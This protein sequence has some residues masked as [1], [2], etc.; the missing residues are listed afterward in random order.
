[1]TP[2]PLRRNLE[3]GFDVS[4]GWLNSEPK[5]LRQTVGRSSREARS[6]QAGFHLFMPP[7]P[8][9]TSD[10]ATHPKIML[11]PQGGKIILSAERSGLRLRL[12][13][14][15]ELRDNKKIT[16]CFQ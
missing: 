7:S 11:A 4:P 12:A 5:V 13:V 16:L 14:L 15:T 8:V 1:M 2:S 6:A 10:T 9:K 3:V